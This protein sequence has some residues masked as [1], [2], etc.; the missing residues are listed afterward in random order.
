MN[1][2]QKATFKNMNLSN[3][4]PTGSLIIEIE[5]TDLLEFIKKEK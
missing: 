5:I 3:T 2:I 1:D 4:I